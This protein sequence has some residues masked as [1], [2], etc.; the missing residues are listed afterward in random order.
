MVLF[1]CRKRELGELGQLRHV[2]W[3]KRLE[4][5]CS[6][7]KINQFKHH[8]SIQSMLI[9]SQPGRACEGVVVPV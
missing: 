9:I 4:V 6:I 7:V 8:A 3:L 1:L 2:S 5:M